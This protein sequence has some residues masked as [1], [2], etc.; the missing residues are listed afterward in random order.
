VDW[1]PRDDD[2]ELA[3]GIDI[4]RP[5][6]IRPD[7]DFQ[8]FETH[9][10][11]QVQARLF[12]AEAEA[13]RRESRDWTSQAT[14]SSSRDFPRRLFLYRTFMQ[15]TRIARAARQHPGGTLLVVVGSLHKDDLERILADEP[16][17]AVVQ[18]STFGEPPDAEVKRAIRPSDRF[19]IATFNLLGLQSEVAIDRDWIAQ[20][21]RDLGATSHEAQLLA[22]R[23]DDLTHRLAP[24]EV[25]ARYESLERITTPDEAFHWTGVKD[26]SRL[27]STFDPFGNLT[28]KQRLQVEIARIAHRL[29]QDARL[30]P[31]LDQLIGQLTPTKAAQLRSY[32]TTYVI[33]PP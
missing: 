22:L 30:P 12:Y 4:N 20:I 14:P 7:K 6:M 21:V 16:G 23:L 19:M 24:A 9:P 32:W 8:S 27:D 17:V 33:S 3:F 2:L 13:S 18:P 26:R 29:G 11:A 15:A 5:P 1:L 10:A 31:I 28:V 25:L